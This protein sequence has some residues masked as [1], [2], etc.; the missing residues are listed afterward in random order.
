MNERYR[1]FILLAQYKSFTE[2]AKHM[3]CSQP[4][5][6]QHIQQ[7]ENELGCQLISRKK[8]QIKLTTQGEIVLAYAQKMQEMDQQLRMAVKQTQQENIKLYISHYIADSF[9][10]ELFDKNNSTLKQ[11]PYEINSFGYEDLKSSLV[12]NH[13][14]FAV[15]PIYDADTIVQ[16]SFDIDILFEEELVLVMTNDHPL[17]SRQIIYTRDLKNLSML[18]S[19]S[20]YLNQHIKQALHQ[21]AVPVYYIQMTNFEIIKKAVQQGMG[22]SFLPYKSIEDSLEKITFKYVKGLCIKRKN[23]IVFNRNHI[24]NEQEQAFCERIKDKL[25]VESVR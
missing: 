19:Q 1:T 17:A 13:A 4:T 21:K 7:L 5:V 3:F 20:S 6:S 10:N 25:K 14:K 2:T 12:K 16:E 15:M 22:V 11:Y 9:F 8:R 23:G 24:L 18:L